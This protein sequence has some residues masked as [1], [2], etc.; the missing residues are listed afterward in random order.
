MLVL[1]GSCVYRRVSGVFRC[2]K[3]EADAKHVEGAREGFALRMAGKRGQLLL[4]VGCAYALAHAIPLVRSH[5]TR[6]THDYGN[7]QTP[8]LWTDQ[9]ARPSRG[10]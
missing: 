8:L 5:R 4:G 3:N 1:D 6:Y 7:G 2:V 9:I 10:L